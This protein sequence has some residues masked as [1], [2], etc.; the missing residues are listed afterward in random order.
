MMTIASITR[1]FFLTATL[2]CSVAVRASEPLFEGLG[3][4]T[5]NIT[6]QSP[7]AQRYFNQGLAWFHGFHH[8]AALRSFE[9]AARLDPDCAMAHW[10][11]ALALG[12]HINVPMVPAPAAEQAWRAITRAQHQAA[13]ATPVERALIA[14]LAR[15]YADPQPDDRTP[16]DRAYAEAMRQTWQAYPEDPDVGALFAEALMTLRPWDLWTQEGR[17][18]PGTEEVIAT[19]DAV[20]KLSPNHPFANHLYIH[21]IEASP[22]PERAAAAADRLRD[23]QPALAHNVHMPSHIDIRS[24][25]WAEA[26]TANM[27]AIAAAEALRA[28]LGPPPLGPI[29]LYNAHNHHMLAYAAMMTGRSELAIRQIRKMVAGMPDDFVEAFAI[30]TDGYVAMPYEVLLRFGRWDDVLAA[31]DHP[32]YLPFARAVR[33]A[34]RGIALAAKGD[35]VAARVEQ[36]AYLGAIPAVPAGTSVGPVDVQAIFAVITPML[37]GEILYQEGEED[38]GLAKLREAVEA[39]D[40]LRYFEPPAWFLPVRHALG[41]ALMRSGRFAE[42]E[43]VY[44]EDLRRAPGNGWSEFGLAESLRAMDRSDEFEAAIARF[45]STW[46][47]ADVEIQ[48]SCMCQPGV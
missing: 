41:A 7:E 31:P 46:S 1:T 20:L 26:I 32:E 5:R 30:V 19:L 45:R 22:H 48:S 12:P 23:L 16:L 3:D 47:N 28:R 17:P 34:A 14:A 44:R 15:R 43:G 35:T 40:D 25:R 8:G 18:Q 13:G 37:E 11:V 42:A 38:A 29:Y 10:G 4:Y 39:E 24:G 21:A 2:V 36:K 6:T 33:R 27:K 9:E